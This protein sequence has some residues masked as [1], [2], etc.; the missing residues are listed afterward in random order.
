MTWQVR[1]TSGDRSRTQLIIS[2]K[3]YDEQKIEI[4]SSFV[5]GSLRGLRRSE[6]EDHVESLFKNIIKLLGYYE[7]IVQVL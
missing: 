2:G 7:S 5:E 6:R 1:K 4:R 3:A